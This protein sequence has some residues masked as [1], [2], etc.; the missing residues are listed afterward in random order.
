MHIFRDLY[1]AQLTFLR[2]CP[3]SVTHIGPR[4]N[5]L[6]K[7][8]ILRESLGAPTNYLENM[9]IFCGLQAK[10]THFCG[11]QEKFALFSE[12]R[13]KTD[14]GL[15]LPVLVNFVY[16]DAN[17]RTIGVHFTGPNSVGVPKT[18]D[19]KY[20]NMSSGFSRVMLAGTIL[21]PS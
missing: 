19:I 3:F 20:S 2:V 4:T 5:P 9:L 8:L 7:V 21:Y 17:S 6:E 16:F 13:A 18:T 15:F 10:N 1:E 12:S 14:M 11:S